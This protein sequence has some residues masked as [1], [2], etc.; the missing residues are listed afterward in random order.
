MLFNLARNFSQKIQAHQI[1]KNVD[2][3]LI[4]KVPSITLTQIRYLMGLL[5]ILKRQLK[6]N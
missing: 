2:R 4:I 5:I 3:D 6:V 1:L